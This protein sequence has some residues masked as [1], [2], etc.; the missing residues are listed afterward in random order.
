[1]PGSANAVYLLSFPNTLDACD[2]SFTPF[3][4]KLEMV[5]RIAGIE[6]EGLHGNIMDKK[7]APKGK[8]CTWPHCACAQCST[9]L[10]TC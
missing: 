5:M 8:V 7:Q 1:M 10:C 4:G 6:Y 3:G 2:L 9:A